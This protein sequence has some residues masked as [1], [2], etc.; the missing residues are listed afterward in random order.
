MG[1]AAYYPYNDPTENVV[2]DSDLEDVDLDDEEVQALVEQCRVYWDVEE[3]VEVHPD[4]KKELERRLKAGHK[5]KAFTD[6]IDENATRA[7][8][9]LA[10]I[11][12]TYVCFYY[13]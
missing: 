12:A 2:D 8:T 1:D 3:N 10:Q 13:V 9:R 6:Q 5:L 11:I 7:G 4:I